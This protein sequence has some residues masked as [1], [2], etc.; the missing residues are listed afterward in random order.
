MLK[1][2]ENKRVV[3]L[4]LFQFCHIGIHNHYYACDIKIFREC[5]CYVYR[6]INPMF[7]AD[8]TGASEL[9]PCTLNVF[10]VCTVNSSTHADQICY[11]DQ[12]Y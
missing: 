9:T 6:S 7:H 11:N 5:N 8:E 1:K 3:L 2:H 4:P 10:T 12:C